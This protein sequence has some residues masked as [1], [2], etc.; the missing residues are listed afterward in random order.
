LA[1]R[2]RLKDEGCP[3]SPACVHDAPSISPGSATC[4]SSTIMRSSL[5]FEG[6]LVEAIENLQG[7]LRD[8]WRSTGLICTRIVSRD[9][10]SRTNGAMA[11]L[12]DRAK[13]TF[14][15]W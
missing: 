9:L 15:V 12:P 6:N 5:S 13:D 1:A 7:G 8:T 10:H 11:G 2:Q 4:R 14:H 3:R